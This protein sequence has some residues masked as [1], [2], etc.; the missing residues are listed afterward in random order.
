VI[1]RKVKNNLTCKANKTGYGAE[2][3]DFPQMKTSRNVHICLH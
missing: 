2:N 1:N 3:I